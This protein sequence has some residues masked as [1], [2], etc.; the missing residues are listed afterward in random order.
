VVLLFLNTL[1]YPINLETFVALKNF[2]EENRC[3]GIVGQ[4]V[5][6]KVCTTNLYTRLKRV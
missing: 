3:F 5:T 4:V 1:L 2:I 6:C